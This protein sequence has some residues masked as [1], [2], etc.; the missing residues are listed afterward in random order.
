MLKIHLAGVTHVSVTDNRTFWRALGEEYG[1]LT[2]ERYLAGRWSNMNEQFLVFGKAPPYGWVYWVQWQQ[3]LHHL[4]GLGLLLI[5]FAAL[6]RP[7]WWRD[8]DWSAAMVRRL[9]AYTVAALAIWI[10]LLLAPE[11]ALVHHSSF[12]TTALL[13]F[14]A[15]ACLANLPNTI[16]V[17]TLTLHVLLSARVWAAWPLAPPVPLSMLQALSP[18]YLWLA[19]LFLAAF[20]IC[21]RFIPDARSDS[22]AQSWGSS[23]AARR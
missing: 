12:A 16:V 3:F 6:L 10:V 20:A 5:G 13:F 17:A 15:S 9:L 22:D 1:K 18:G 21:L 7:R 14:Y 11:S 4:P 2:L 23:R 8:R 19:A